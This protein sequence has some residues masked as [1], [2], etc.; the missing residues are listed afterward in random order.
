[1]KKLRTIGDPCLVNIL[2]EECELTVDVYQDGDLLMILAMQDELSMG[3]MHFT[4]SALDN[5][6]ANKA[7]GITDE[8]RLLTAFSHITDC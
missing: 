4:Q 1:M 7:P 2:D 8:H 6:L 3:S 5:F